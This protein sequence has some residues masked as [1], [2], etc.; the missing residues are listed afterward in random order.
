MMWLILI[1]IALFVVLP[2][3]GLWTWHTQEMVK[4]KVKNVQEISPNELGEMKMEIAELRQ[5]IT[6]LAINVENMKD[7]NVHVTAL[8][9]R[10]KVNQ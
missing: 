2:L 10:M 9:D 4:L 1:A 7:N 3:A 6:S 8:E 5:M